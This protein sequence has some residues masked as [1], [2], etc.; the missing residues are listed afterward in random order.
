MLADIK[1]EP[2]KEGLLVVRA[3]IFLLPGRVDI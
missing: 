3:F 1:K 2:I